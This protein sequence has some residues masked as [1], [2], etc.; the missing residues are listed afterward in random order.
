MVRN[1]TI[2]RK[3]CVLDRYGEIAGT[4]NGRSIAHIRDIYAFMH[5]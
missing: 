1:I 5:R 3:Y 4:K 2:G